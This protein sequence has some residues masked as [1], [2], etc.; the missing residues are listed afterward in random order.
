MDNQELF[1]RYINGE[2]TE[3]ERTDFDNRV[4]SDKDFA[5]DFRLHLFVVWGIRREAE[6]DN[7]DFGVAMKRLTKRQLQNIV[8]PRRRSLLNFTF[9]DEFKYSRASYSR[10]QH[11][12]RV[13]ENASYCEEDSPVYGADAEFSTCAPAPAESETVEE[14]SAAEKKPK[15]VSFWP[16]VWQVSTVVAV[17]I[18]AFVSVFQIDKHNRYNVD[19][20]IYE[21]TVSDITPSRSGAVTIDIHEL[22]DKELKSAL[23]KLAEAYQSASDDEEIANNGYALALA[24]LR[25]HNREEA[26][27]V[28]NQLVER[29]ENNELFQDR[30]DRY[31]YALRLIK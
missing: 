18:V 17:V 5:K 11:R 28:L 15:T 8:T 21:S 22:S 24:Y 3:A 25:L 27:K 10:R 30:V 4:K 6:Q 20:A 1:D 2:L 31:R 29:F 7:L 16:R 12:N 13:T 9:S 14:G 26:R 23:P 19:N